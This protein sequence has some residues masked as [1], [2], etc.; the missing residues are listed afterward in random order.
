MGK[1]SIEAL[2]YSKWKRAGKP[3]GKSLDFW[4]EAEKEWKEFPKEC[5][6]LPVCPV[7]NTTD[8]VYENMYA[9]MDAGYHCRCG[10]EWNSRHISYNE[11][12]CR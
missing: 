8:S 10:I 5:L 11:W 1:M 12:W 9:I 3:E 6:K 2:A 7:C 4:L